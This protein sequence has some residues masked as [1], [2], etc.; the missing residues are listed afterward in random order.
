MT[1]NIDNPTMQSFGHAAHMMIN[2]I[3]GSEF[4]GVNF[5]MTIK[6]LISK[7]VQDFTGDDL[8]SIRRAIMAARSGSLGS[9]A[10]NCSRELLRTIMHLDSQ[11]S[12]VAVQM[13]DAAAEFQRKFV[14]PESERITWLSS[15]GT[16]RI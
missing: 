12:D 4:S 16:F 15:I 5:W 8:N 7:S 14:H 1:A 9:L 3:T 6:P 13:I 11:D 10:Q 2:D